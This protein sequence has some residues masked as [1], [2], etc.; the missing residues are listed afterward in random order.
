MRFVIDQFPG[1][2]VFGE[3]GSA[4]VVPINPFGQVTGGADIKTVI[5]LALDYIK[6]KRH[7]AKKRPVTD[8]K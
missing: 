4:L 7:R 5:L 6:V 3:F 2:F 8:F 1:P